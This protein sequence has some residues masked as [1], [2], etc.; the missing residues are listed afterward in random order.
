MTAS[1]IY[2]GHFVVGG[3]DHAGQL[4]IDGKKSSL[5]I[6]G[7][8]FL[9]VP[10]E[11]MKRVIGI[12]KDGQSITCA[13]CV[14]VKDGGSASYYGKR[15][16]FL[17][18][19]PNRVLIGPRHINPEEKE[20]AELTFC[21]S[22]ANMLFYDWGTFGHIIYDHPLSFGQKREILKYVQGSP[23]RRRRGGDLDLYFHWN[24]A[25]IIEVTTALGTITAH[26][27][28]DYPLTSTDGLHLRG[29]VRVHVKLSSPQTLEEVLRIQFVIM[30][31]CEFVA[32]GKQNLT[33]MEVAHK[34]G[35]NEAPLSL[36]LS[37]RQHDEIDSLQPTDALV[38]G[39][40]NSEEF[41]RML[42]AWLETHEGR[43]GAR[44]RFVDG[45]RNGRSYNADRL[46]GAANAFDLLPASD[47]VKAPT[48][49]PDV[50]TLVSGWEAEV[51]KAAVASKDVAEHK[52]R[53][54]NTLGL[55]RKANLRSKVLTCYTELPA[56]LK[57]RLPEME[58]VI[59]H[60]I[61]ARNFFVH[62]TETKMTAEQVYGHAPFFTDTL[63]FI[64]AAYELKK[65]GW[66][67]ARWLKES[68]SD[69]RLKWYM[70]KYKQ[71]VALVKASLGGNA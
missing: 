9:H 22:K 47:F 65:C 14:G 48:L 45:F 64:F 39:G 36:F 66:N 61:R 49:P 37:Q 62:G 7:E 41:E 68:F 34:D 70:S 42:K 58:W 12:A 55:V 8:E 10:N 60:C 20:I 53:L 40:I 33:H 32:Q 27:D 17:S 46:V 16:H 59:A 3:K 29:Q 67:I 35:K 24:R 28:T 26:T 4:V 18:L 30:E 5:E 2:L 71:H 21:F 57:K 69:S 52:D 56:E 51:G 43:S 54:T 1:N 50:E 44:R 25:P 11:E 63:E 13:N 15:R 6:Y 23:K 19:F 38:N 31:F